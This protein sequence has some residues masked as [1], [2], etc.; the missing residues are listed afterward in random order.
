M[1]PAVN[2]VIRGHSRKPLSK[3]VNIRAVRKDLVT[4][5]AAENPSI[6]Y[7]VIPVERERESATWRERRWKVDPQHRFVEHVRQCRALRIAYV[8]ERHAPIKLPVDKP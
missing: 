7:L 1:L 2:V 6:V 4:R 3:L 8:R 5:S